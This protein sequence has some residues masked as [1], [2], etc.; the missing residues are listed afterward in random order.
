MIPNGSGLLIYS[1]GNP[2]RQDDGL[3]PAFAAEIER[4]HL[5][6]VTVDVNYQPSLEDAEYIAGFDEVIFVDA[7]VEGPKP[8][9]LKP[10]QPARLESFSTHGVSAAAVYAMAQDM[11]GAKTQAYLLGIRGYSFAMFVETLT[12]EAAAN[13]AAAVNELVPV[14]R[15]RQLSAAARQRGDQH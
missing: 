12:E 11:F 1:Y 9:A 14:L 2:A 4:L 7:A 15:A 6:D 8:F 10:L 13:L 3:G 5:P